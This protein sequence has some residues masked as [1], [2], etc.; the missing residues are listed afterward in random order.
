MHSVTNYAIFWLPSGYHFDTPTL[1]QP[2]PNASDTNYESLVGQYFRDL[3]NTAYYSIVQQYTDSSGA[4][5]TGDWLRGLL[6]RHVA[7]SQLGGKQGQPAPRLGHR[8]RGR[9]GH[10]RERLVGGQRQQRVLRIH[11]GKT[12]SAARGPAA[13]TRHYCAYHS[14]FQASTARP[15]CTPT[16]PIRATR[17]RHLPCHGGDRLC[18]P[19][20]RRLRG[21][22]GQPRRA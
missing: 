10:E 8:G 4:P 5:G 17:S 2:Y 6:G 3:S 11:R 1:D 22:R 18:R 15:S 16:S 9:E 20:R 21:L 19:E 13:P 7:V 14:A 12:S